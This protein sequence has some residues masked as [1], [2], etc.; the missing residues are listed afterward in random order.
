MKRAE[1]S[2]E[3]APPVKQHFAMAELRKKVLDIIQSTHVLVYS[4][5]TCP[6]CD[7]VRRMLAVFFHNS[8]FFSIQV[9]LLFKK[10]LIDATYVELDK[11]GELVR[12]TSLLSDF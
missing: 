10:M 6:F 2:Y 3:C 11:T 4:K 8:T 12:V 5:T 7:R 1:D 9:K